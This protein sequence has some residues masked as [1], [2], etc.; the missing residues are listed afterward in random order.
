M[1]RTPSTLHYDAYIQKQCVQ[2]VLDG[3]KIM[4]EMSP[5]QLAYDAWEATAFEKKWERGNYEK[6][7]RISGVSNGRALALCRSKL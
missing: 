7:D 5:P 1:L 2:S 3:K 4:L 6:K